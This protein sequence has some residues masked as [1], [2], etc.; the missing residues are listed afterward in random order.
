MATKH[1]TVLEALRTQ[2]DAALGAT[3]T[4][5][6]NE[7]LPQNVPSGGWV[8]QPDGDPKKGD[9]IF[10][11][12]YEID[13]VVELEVIVQAATNTLRAAAMEA[14]LVPIGTALRADLTLGGA[15]ESLEIGQP[16]SGPVSEVGTEDWLGTTVPI[17]L[18]YTS[19]DGL[20]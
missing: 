14:L 4:V 5:T 15:V 19:P 7:G 9:Y 8:N 10:G 2:I 16:S 1:E 18:L 11:F 3:I 12:G 20:S 13:H 17:T 6:R